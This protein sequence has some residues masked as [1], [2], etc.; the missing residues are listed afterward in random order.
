M[1]APLLAPVVAAAGAGGA[2]R[3]AARR[4]TR[5]RGGPGRC[6]ELRRREPELRQ[7][8]V[9]GG[10]LLGAGLE[11]V[12]DL[13]RKLTLVATDS[14]SLP[15]LAHVFVNSSVEMDCA[16][17]RACA[18]NMATDRV[19]S[20][21]LR[22]QGEP[23]TIAALRAPQLVLAS[24]SAAPAA[25]TA[26]GG[27]EQRNADADRRATCVAKST[28][29]RW[30]CPIHAATCAANPA[31]KLRRGKCI[32]RTPSPTR[33]PS[34]REPKRMPTSPTQHP[35]R[36]H[37]PTRLTKAGDDVDDVQV[38]V[39]SEPSQ[40]WPSQLWPFGRPPTW[41]RPRRLICSTLLLPLRE[42]KRREIA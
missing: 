21:P 25:A 11:P 4:A 6:D 33:R 32:F 3:A 41:S 42:R 16:S 7:Q 17:S 26:G 20:T 34:T 18:T 23:A 35:T 27:Q 5:E 22:N 36:K 12:L 13:R 1:R 39:A 14:W 8:P 10:A 30:S 24:I 40:L 28:I 15:G 37:D 29:S 38:L 31:C 2:G 19:Y 9:P